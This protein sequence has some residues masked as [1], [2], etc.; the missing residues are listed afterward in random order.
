MAWR[1]SASVGV[2]TGS[3]GA[4]WVPAGGAGAGAGA[5]MGALGDG[6]GAPSLPGL[7]SPHATNPTES[8]SSESAEQNGAERRLKVAGRAGIKAP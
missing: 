3:S 5:E 6:E 1:T 7:L 2:K 8:R 4:A